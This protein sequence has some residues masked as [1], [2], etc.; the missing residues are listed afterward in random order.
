MR[1][2]R[3]PY[4]VKKESTDLTIDSKKIIIG[5]WSKEQIESTKRI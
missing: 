2:N 3:Y 4:R 5:K 1:P